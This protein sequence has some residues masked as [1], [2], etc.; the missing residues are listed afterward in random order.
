MPRQKASTSS[1][2]I[3]ISSAHSSSHP[4]QT[5]VARV[6]PNVIPRPNAR[7]P[8]Y[9]AWLIERACYF[10]TIVETLHVKLRANR[11]TEQ[12]KDA[13]ETA[14]R[15]WDTAQFAKTYLLNDEAARTRFYAHID[16][17]L[18]WQPNDLPTYVHISFNATPFS[19]SGEHALS[20]WMMT[21]AC[22]KGSQA[23]VSIE[24]QNKPA[25][26]REVV[27]AMNNAG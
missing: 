5:R 1:V 6:K 15:N 17:I 24:C 27:H 22:F 12:Q 7:D 9:K 8:A 19:D 25:L 2:P 20:V 23:I 4:A 14:E 16:Y 3:R 21:F 11:N 10:A 18:S 13:H 26:K